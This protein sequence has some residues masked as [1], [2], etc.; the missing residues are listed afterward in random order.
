[1]RPV[2]DRREVEAALAHDYGVPPHVVGDLRFHETSGDRLYV[3]AEGVGDVDGPAAATRVERVGLYFATWTRHG[4]R[5]STEGAELVVDAAEP[6]VEVEDDEARAWFAGEDIPFPGSSYLPYVIL[7]HD[8]MVLGCGL[9][10][11]GE[12]RNRLPK[13]RRIPREAVVLGD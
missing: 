12:V 13:E 2:D 10:L 7:V 9:I 4:L 8:G 6:V 11:G 1:M 3:A 5:L